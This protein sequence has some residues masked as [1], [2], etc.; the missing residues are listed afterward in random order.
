[1]PQGLFGLQKS[2]CS[3]TLIK[4]YESTQS[5]CCFFLFFLIYLC[6]IL[7]I[8]FDKV[9]GLFRELGLFFLNVLFVSVHLFLRSKKS[10][11]EKHQHSRWKRFWCLFEEFWKVHLFTS[12]SDNTAGIVARRSTFTHKD[13]TQ[14]LLPV[15]VTDSGS[16]ALSSTSTLTISVC[17][18]QPPGHCPRGGVKAFALPMGVSL[19]TLLGLVVCL[20]TLT[21]KR[22]WHSL[23][24][25][26]YLSPEH[27]ALM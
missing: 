12:L 17:S 15:V 4:S 27:R 21:G 18:C 19:Q 22:A 10:P 6:K 25:T 14:Y 11:T 24:F 9:F 23:V 13:Q 8:K 2:Y 16:P 3:N 20:V 7:K 5:C 1:M 26:S